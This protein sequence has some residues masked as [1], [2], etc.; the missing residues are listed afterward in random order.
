MNDYWV[1]YGLGV[2]GRVIVGF[3]FGVIPLIY[4]LAK[5]QSTRALTAFS[6]CIIAG[7]FCGLVLA[8]FLSLFYLWKIYKNPKDEVD[9]GDD[10][11]GLMSLKLNSK[12]RDKEEGKENEG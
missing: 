4:G 1:V 10:E 11:S 6:T 8:P 5:G 9:E 12:S 3:V 7:F 2:I